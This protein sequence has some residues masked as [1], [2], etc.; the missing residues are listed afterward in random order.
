[1]QYYYS[2]T[3]PHFAA[4]RH[5]TVMDTYD[6]HDIYFIIIAYKLCYMYRSLTL[7]LWN[8]QLTS[9]RYRCFSN[10]IMNF[11]RNA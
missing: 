3:Q 2:F 6:W 7:T 8:I 4:F 11:S 9:S 1:M 5:D 10:G